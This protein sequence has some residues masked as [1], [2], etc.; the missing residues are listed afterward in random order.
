MRRRRD[1]R[2]CHKC[3]WFGHIVYYC[4]KKEIEEKKKRKSEEENKRFVFLESKVYKR[5]EAVY[6]YE[7]KEQQ[8]VRC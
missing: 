7:R 3:K 4:R 6:S 5:I 8:V 1:N 2:R